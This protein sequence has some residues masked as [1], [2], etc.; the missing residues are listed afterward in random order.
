MLRNIAGEPASTSDD[1]DVKLS[2]V[3]LENPKQRATGDQNMIPGK[4]AV[5][6]QPIQN[7]SPVASFATGT[8]ST[9][10]DA[11]ATQNNAIYIEHDTAAQK[12]FRWRSIKALLRQSKQLDFS[13]RSEDYV[14]SYEMN[15][16]VLRFYG[17][18]RQM[19]DTGYGSD[20]S[21]AAAS[22]AASSISGISDEAS[23]TGSPAST[24]ENLWGTGFIPTVTESRPVSDVGGLNGDNTLKLD[25]KTISRLLKSYLDNIHI[26]HPF[27]KEGELTKQVE[28]FKQRYNPHEPNSSKVGFAVPAVDSLRDPY[29]ARAPKRKHSDGHY[30][31]SL[32]EPGLAPSPPSLKILLEKSPETAKILLVMALGRICEWREPLPG[33]VPDNSKDPNLMLRPYSPRTDSPPPTYPLRQSPSSSS[34]TTTTT[35]AP[36]P[37]TLGRFANS[38]PRSSVSELPAGARNVDVIPGLAYYAQ[39]SD[40]LGNLT[41]YHELINAQCC[42]LAGLYAGQLANTLESLTWIQAA[43]RICRFLVKEPNFKAVRE[44]KKE[45]IKLAFWTSLQLES[46]ILAELDIP[47]SGIQEVQQDVPYPKGTVGQGELVDGDTSRPE[48]MVYYS[49]QLHMRKLLNDI[50]KELYQ[51]KDANFIRATRSTSLR[52]AFDTMI[53]NWRNSLPEKLQWDDASH[54]VDNINDSRLRGKFYGAQY[55]IHRP[56]LHAALDYDFE[57]TEPYLKSP[58]NDTFANLQ[59]H[60]PSH[61]APGPEMG[62]PKSISDYERRRHETI[63]LAV[64]CIKAATRS[65]VAFDGVLDHRRMVVTNIM[66]T[67]HA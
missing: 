29:A 42:L 33:P 63:E 58:P 11:V 6:D 55:I 16:G 18:G 50:Q 27:L 20:T 64:I 14:M 37:I 3:K 12:L 32:G 5:R 47:P 30:Y 7:D 8:D 9:A 40:I 65:T 19:R 60:L 2:S 48:V 24:P 22:P 35:S 62:P 15:K 43:S 66:G 45:S 25:S 1:A 4:P 13:D 46:D 54:I 26:L 28:R 36:S 52:N 59:N 23:S 31:S 34:H 49:F 21:T 51:E 41:G 17:K 44:P 39:A 57:E 10:T 61:P 56:F 53:N 38:S 67:A